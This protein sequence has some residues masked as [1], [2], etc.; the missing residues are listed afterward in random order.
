MPAERR[1]ALAEEVCAGLSA[2]FKELS[3]KWFYDERGSQ[4]FEQ[5]TR[6]PEYYPTRCEREILQA[7]AGQIVRLTQVDTL[8]EL[9][10]GTSEKTRLLLQALAEADQ[11]RRFAPFDVSEPT[12]RQ[13]AAA[14][15]R[16]YPRVEVH[17]VVGDFERHLPYLPRQGRRLIAFLG[18]TLGNLK[19]TARAR[20]LSQLA[21]QLGPEDAL[22][23]GTDLVKDRARLHAAYN[24][25]RGVTAAFN[26]NLLRV[27]NQEL[28][29]DFQP[30][31]F[32]HLAFFDEANEWMEMRLVS[33]RAHR[34]RLSALPLSAH[35]DGGEALRTEVS[36]K[37]RPQGVE[38]ELAA[39]GLTVRAF[40]TDAGGDFALS[41][42]TL[43]G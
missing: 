14:I 42:S 16:E 24:D 22:L 4:L 25:P 8:V 3:S 9:G 27:L 39:A 26:L 21:A 30:E 36:A 2:P 41:L 20:F 5:I 12:L 38:R 43:S 40:W 32:S 15:A 13:A 31:L 7:R 6:L 33:H 28:G 23:L 1:A 37:F 11:L 10:S 35:F 19:P 17:A 29:G 34:V 18:G